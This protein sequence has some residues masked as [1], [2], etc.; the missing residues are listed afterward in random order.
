MLAA[1]EISEGLRRAM[2]DRGKRKFVQSVEL[3]VNLRDID[4]KKPE[5]RFTETVELPRGLGSRPRRVAVIAGG[6]LAVEAR[7]SANIDKVLEREEVELLVGNKKAAKKLAREYDYFLVDTSLISLAARALGSAL[8]YVGKAP[9]PVPAGTD[10][11]A[12]AARYK[13]SVTVRVRKNPQANC[14]IGTEEMP[15]DHLLENAQAVLNRV[16]ERLP[17]RWANVQ[18][19]YL[20]LSMG[21]PVRLSVRR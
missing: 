4:L 3:Q 8:G 15:I 13:R 12:M 9:V 20:K 17:K 16:V 7:K 1:Q 21:E 18:S 19:V 11:D 14:V 5:N 6:A 10:I 2:G